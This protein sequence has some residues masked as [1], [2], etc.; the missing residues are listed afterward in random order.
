MMSNETN[1]IFIAIT[2]CIQLKTPHADLLKVVSFVLF[3]KLQHRSV[4]IWLV[5][6]YHLQTCPKFMK[7]LAASLWITSFDDQLAT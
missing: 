2:L 3:S 7:Q 6:T 5:A 4:K 1:F